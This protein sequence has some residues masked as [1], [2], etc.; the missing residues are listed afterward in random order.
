MLHAGTVKE[1]EPL[2]C[3]ALALLIGR[4]VIREQTRIIVSI[5]P[6]SATFPRVRAND[7]HLDDLEL[8]DAQPWAEEDLRWWL[9]EAAV[10]SNVLSHALAQ[11]IEERSDQPIVALGELL[12]GDVSDFRIEV[13]DDQDVVFAAD[14]EEYILKHRIADAIE[15]AIAYMLDTLEHAIVHEGYAADFSGIPFSNGLLFISEH[16]E[17]KVRGDDPVRDLG[18]ELHQLPFCPPIADGDDKDAMARRDEVARQIGVLKFDYH[19]PDVMNLL[20]AVEWCNCHEHAIVN[21]FDAMGDA[22]SARTAAELGGPRLAELASIQQGKAYDASKMKARTVNVFLSSKPVNHFIYR[23]CIYFAPN[24]QKDW[25]KGHRFIEWVLAHNK[26]DEGERWIFEGLAAIRGSRNGVFW[27]NAVAIC[28]W[29]RRGIEFLERQEEVEKAR[30]AKDGGATRRYLIEMGK[31]GP[32]IAQLHAMGILYLS[33]YLPFMSAVTHIEDV[34]DELS[35]LDQAT[36][37]ALSAAADEE[38]IEELMGRADT[39]DLPGI[40][41]TEYD[42]VKKATRRKRY[43]ILDSLSEEM[44]ATGE[45]TKE[46]LMAMLEKGAEAFHRHTVERQVE[47]HNDQAPDK[48]VGIAVD[49]PEPR[50]KKMRATTATAAPQERMFGIT[51][52]VHDQAPSLLNLHLSGRVRIRLDR[53]AT[54]LKECFQRGEVSHEQLIAILKFVAA[55]ARRRR[56]RV[57]G[58]KGEYTTLGKLRK[59]IEDAL[60]DELARK[61]REV[62]EERQRLESVRITTIAQ[63]E[64]LSPQALLEQLRVFKRVDGIDIKLSASSSKLSRILVL[65]D[66]I[67]TKFGA[68]AGRK[69]TQAQAVTL[70]GCRVRS[71]GAS[72]SRSTAGGKRGRNELWEV[73]AVVGARWTAAGG[74]EYLIRWTAIN[75]ATNEKWETWSNANNFYHNGA[76]HHEIAEQVAELDKVNAAE[77][78]ANERNDLEVE[79]LETCALAMGDKVLY[80]GKHGFRTGTVKS[81]ATSGEL[82]V[83][84]DVIHFY[85]DQ[86]GRLA[87]SEVRSQRHRTWDPSLLSP[88]SHHYP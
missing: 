67:A 76:I 4:R 63:L 49:L 5:E 13:P 24:S 23:W 9:K 25:A 6:L 46:L 21:T 1:L 26:L 77:Q 20:T 79:K 15:A 75:P 65:N 59:E 33:L 82:T 2:K 11:V 47:Q 14:V 52:H 36:Y 55:E 72:S 45:L 51:R 12:S 60:L 84:L 85:A 40:L 7:S 57:G 22:A 42:R 34:A 81:I 30:K 48:R 41:P 29:L 78:L 86:G 58:R 3:E 37:R 18:S 68:A 74:R 70:A 71:E 61:E 28:L 80:D 43:A 62:E 53:A 54:W 64:G 19:S 50:K 31:E 44:I 35:K 39:D 73:D 17:G 83:R 38:Y 56:R 16:L 69:L 87:A 88:Y 32:V 27:A 66:L 10:A 8:R